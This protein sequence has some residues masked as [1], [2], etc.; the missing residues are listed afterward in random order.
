MASKTYTINWSDD[1]L[2]QPFSVGADAKDTKTTSLT[3]IGVGAMD[4]GKEY[5]ENLVHLL[6]NFASNSK[7][8]DSPTAGQT[9][10]NSAENVLK[11]YSPD[12]V[13][14]DV[15]NRR[16]DSTIP[17]V[18]RFYPGD[19]WFDS[20]ANQLRVYLN[21]GV[22][23][24]PMSGALVIPRPIPVPAPTYTP[25][26][27]VPVTPTPLPPTYTPAPVPTP[28]V[29]PAYTMPTHSVSYY[30]PDWVVGIDGAS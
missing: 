25:S 9:W 6:E 16:I 2:K 22:W 20:G 7:P 26:P 13:W 18:G 24:D 1:T 5:Q 11:V 12:N 15:K 4:W 19:L 3:L 23:S 29:I 27:A 21:E 30:G 17:P 28:T 14:V 8:P 10:F